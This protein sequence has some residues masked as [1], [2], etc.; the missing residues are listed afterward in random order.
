MYSNGNKIYLS[1]DGFN[2]YHLIALTSFSVCKRIVLTKTFWAVGPWHHSFKTKLNSNQA[3]QSWA[4][5]PLGPELLVGLSGGVLFCFFL[6]WL[7]LPAMTTWYTQRW[8]THVWHGT[9]PLP[10]PEGWNN[11]WSPCFSAL[12]SC[13]ACVVGVSGSHIAS[14]VDQYQ[15]K[16]LFSAFE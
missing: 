5:W 16:S 11:A 3:Y 2:T 6:A 9:L 1:F 14:S 15:S 12:I 8:T 10:L 4:F 13:Q 7:G